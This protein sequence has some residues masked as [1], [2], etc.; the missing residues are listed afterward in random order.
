MSGNLSN[1][2]QVGEGR[3]DCV[4]QQVRQ[5]PVAKRIRGT[6]RKDRVVSGHLKE[7]KTVHK[8]GGCRP[9]IQTRLHY[10][11]NG[12]LENT[13]TCSRSNWCTVIVR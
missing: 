10:K 5:L 4:G 6:A 8:A 9:V 12:A 7:G 3:G 13:D 11:L 1:E 2:R